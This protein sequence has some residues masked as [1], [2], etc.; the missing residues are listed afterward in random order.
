MFACLLVCLVAA[1]NVSVMSVR[2]F[3]MHTST[4]QELMCL[5]QG[6]NT[7]RPM[8][9]ESANPRSRVKHSTTEQL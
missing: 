7:L 6:H 5:A 4:K 8:R 3:L 2:V 1:N 9:L